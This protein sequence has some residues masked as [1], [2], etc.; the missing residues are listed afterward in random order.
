MGH[1][2]CRI[3]ANKPIS[4]DGSVDT[5]TFNENKVVDLKK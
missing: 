2:A 4:Q 1:P 5:Q 3:A